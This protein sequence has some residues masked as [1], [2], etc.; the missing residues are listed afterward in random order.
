ME[1]KVI[2]SSVAGKSKALAFFEK[3]KAKKAEAVK[4]MEER[5]SGTTELFKKRLQ[6]AVDG[7]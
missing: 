7:L 2:I 5:N 3:L 4:R 6:K 1:K